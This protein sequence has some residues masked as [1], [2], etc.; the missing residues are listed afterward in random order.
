MKSIS[1][2]SDSIPEHAN[3]AIELRFP[4]CSV[5]DLDWYSYDSDDV[6]DDRKPSASGLSS[7]H[8][9]TRPSYTKLYPLPQCQCKIKMAVPVTG[10]ESLI[11]N[12]E[13]HD[14]LSNIQIH[15]FK[16]LA[17]CKPCL[18]K[19][20]EVSEEILNYDYQQDNVENGQR[21][22]KYSI[23]LQCDHCKQK[24]MKRK[25]DPEKLQDQGKQVLRVHEKGRGIKREFDWF[26]SV[27]ATIKLLG[28]MKRRRRRARREACKS[29]KI[30]N[31]NDLTNNIW[32]S[33]K[34][35]DGSSDECFSFSSGSESDDETPT[36]QRHQ[37][38]VAQTGAI[39]QE[40]LHELDKVRK[41]RQEE[42]KGD[43]ELAK[44]LYSESV[45]P[46]VEAQLKRE[47]EDYE[48]AKKLQEKE[49]TEAKRSKILTPSQKIGKR[50]VDS[51]TIKT[52]FSKQSKIEHNSPSTLIS[53]SVE[54]DDVSSMT[55]EEALN[56]DLTSLINLGFSKQD[57]IQ[58]M[59][60]AE[61]NLDLA[62]AMLLSAN[63]K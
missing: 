60:D 4:R 9:R 38:K 16:H 3:K 57:A 15:E 2:D 37:M 27:D 62:A 5:C 31:H 8:T 59:K 36:Y 46:E 44:K 24:F 54:D 47:R 51:Q 45:P 20:I 30:G 42:E 25:L 22:L 41:E 13:S 19:K 49:D 53:D 10:I 23:K 1:P 21:S 63:A 39:K 35:D 40:Y 43:E 32:T 29:R 14:V 17:I 26:D 6:E 18:V 7:P 34:F 33:V 58:A 56:P 12:G 48:L 61:G 52:L 28:W 55:E 11:C 50:K